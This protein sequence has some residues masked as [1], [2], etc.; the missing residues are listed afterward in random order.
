MPLELRAY[1]SSDERSDL[2]TLR[3]LIA[4]PSLSGELDTLQG[5]GGLERKL[6]DPYLVAPLLTL[7]FVDGAPA[8]FA[9]AF[10]L[11]GGNGRF[12]VLRVAVLERFRR[13]GVGGA[14]LERVA[15]ELGSFDPDIRTESMGAW[16]PNP[17]ADRF[18]ARHGFAHARWFW[19]M[20]RPIGPIAEPVWP[21]G[22]STER[23]DGSGQRARD[24]S[25]AYNDSF[26]NHFGTVLSTPE[27]VHRILSRP[28][29]SPDALRLA[30]RNGRCAGFC[31]CELFASR[32]EIAV[33]GT[34]HEARGIGL[35]RALLRWGVR[36]L[37][38]AGTPRVT[39][40]VDGENET[41]LRLYRGEGFEV[42]RTRHIW[43]RL[44]SADRG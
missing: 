38:A 42:A 12:A 18:I 6:A 24:M 4:D 26:A 21:D 22:V 13:R 23:W 1:E 28:G 8:G 44:R 35:G 9:G 2:E 40:V 27:I 20:E 34:T 32:G 43:T 5:K 16:Q 29:V 30:Y 25:D 41:A 39:L 31:R 19:L 11:D 33:L 15:K 37:E 17:E 7:A 3:T 14:L 36:W 10:A